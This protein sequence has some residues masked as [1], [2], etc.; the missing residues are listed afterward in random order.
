MRHESHKTFI[1]IIKAHVIEWRKRE[2]WSRETVVQAIVEAHES[3]GGP[4]NTGIRFEPNTSDAFERQKVNADRVFRWLDDET[5]DNNLLPVNFVQSIL[6]AMPMDIRMHCA[7]E[8]L[9]PLG[10]AAE[11]IDKVDTSSLNATAHLVKIARETSEAQ[12]AVA[13]LIDGATPDELE[14]ADRELAD[15]EQAIHAARLAV[16]QQQ[17]TLKVVA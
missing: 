8:L 9:R 5:K 6:A 7:G 1:G 17:K 10:L 13:D 16:R 12:T 4:A 3:I 11:C 15:A 2:S 14:R